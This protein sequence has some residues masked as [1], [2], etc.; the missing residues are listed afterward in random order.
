M[1]FENFARAP[2][3]T[4][5]GAGG[6]VFENLFVLCAL[7][8]PGAAVPALVKQ[9]KA[10]G[11]LR[12]NDGAVCDPW[13]TGRIEVP[14]RRHQK[15][16]VRPVEHRQDQGP[17][18]APPEARCVNR[19]APAGPRSPR[20]A[21]TNTSSSKASKYSNRPSKASLGPINSLWGMNEA[22]PKW[23]ACITVHPRY[24]QGKSQGAT[25]T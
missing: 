7:R 17:P 11:I 24:G 18:E 1:V 15:H 14:P 4:P 21:A 10:H 16:E 25:R 22:W 12:R 13:S 9:Q 19:E 2:G 5:H 6:V 3:D 8:T 23:L 20:G